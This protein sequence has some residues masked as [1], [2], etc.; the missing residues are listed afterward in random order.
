LGSSYPP[1]IAASQLPDLADHEV[2]ASAV[3]RGC[4]RPIPDWRERLL[5]V[6]RGEL[7][8]TEGGELAVRV[9]N[10]AGCPRCGDS[11][12]EIRVHGAASKA[13]EG[14]R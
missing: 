9:E 7:V 6:V 13:A 8:A 3:C 11:R 1:A 14:S 4:N 12:A 10:R 5:P 2:G